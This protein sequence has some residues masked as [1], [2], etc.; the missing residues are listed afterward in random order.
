[1]MLHLIFRPSPTTLYLRVHGLFLLQMVP[2]GFHWVPQ[3]PILRTV[4]GQLFGYGVVSFLWLAPEAC[5][6]NRH[7]RSSQA[8]LGRFFLSLTLCVMIVPNLALW[9]GAP[10]AVALSWLAFVGLVVLGCLVLINLGCG[11]RMILR[12]E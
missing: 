3:G 10:G 6:A 7:R 11:L 5:G 1:M 2:F 9:G 8:G 12:R 4:T